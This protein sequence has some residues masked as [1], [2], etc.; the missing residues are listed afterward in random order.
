MTTEQAIRLISAIS[1]LVGVLIWPL[2]IL[3]VVIRF[4]AGLADFFGHL[5]EFTFK[6]PGLEA[7]A[8]RQQVE[9]AAALGAASAAKTDRDTPGLTPTPSEVAEVVTAAA[10]ADARAQR[11]QSGVVLW[12][13]DKPDNNRYERQALEAFGVRFVLSTSTEDALD[14]TQRQTFDLIISDMARP[15]DRRAGLTLLD[16]LRASGN[17]TPYL[18]YASS[19]ARD[20]ADEARRLGALGFAISPQELIVMASRAL[21]SPAS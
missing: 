10:A 15:S 7:S 4:R 14:Q 17:H 20:L 13:D 6:A 2:L 18:I 1:G 19:R 16:R 11:L 8:R 12:V 5:G 9:A 21:G 3:F